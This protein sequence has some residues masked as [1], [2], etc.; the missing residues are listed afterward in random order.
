MKAH[1]SEEK[2]DE[3]KLQEKMHENKKLSAPLKRMQEEVVQLQ[4]E[5][6]VEIF[7]EYVIYID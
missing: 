6:E 7:R 3:L 4:Q 5:L 2:K 1:E